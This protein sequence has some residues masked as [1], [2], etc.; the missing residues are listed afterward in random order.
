MQTRRDRRQ[1]DLLAALPRN[2]L[3]PEDYVLKRVN[4]VVDL[5]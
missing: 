5:F 4:K 3:G 2:A 1:E